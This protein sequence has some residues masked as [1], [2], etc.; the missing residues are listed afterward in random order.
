MT[1]TNHTA[2]KAA[3][4]SLM[5]KPTSTRTPRLIHAVLLLIT[6]GLS[7]LVSAILGPNIP[8]LQEHFASQIAN[9]DQW[10]PLAVSIPIGVFGVC[11]IF[12]GSLSDRIGR[13]N[14]LLWS[15]LLYAIF[16][17][18]PFYIDNFWV[19]FASRVALGV[20]EAAVMTA[21]ATMI[22]DYYTGLKRER[23]ISLQTTMASATATVF[24]AV[25]TAIGAIGWNAPFAV[26]GLALLL[27][28][29][30]AIYLWEPKPK[31][32]NPAARDALQDDGTV[33]RP[34]LLALICLTGFFTGIA[35]MLVPINLAV[36]YVA[37][38]WPQ[39]I[40]V[41][42]TLNSAGVMLATFVFGW[43]L[44]GRTSIG[45]QLFVSL[46]VAG[47]G[48]LM[49]GKASSPDMLTAGAVVNGFGCGLMLPATV[50]WTMR[51]LPFSK[52]GFGIGAF[53]SAQMLGM[54]ISSLVVVTLGN[55]IGSRAAGVAQFGIWMLSAAVIA[56]A[57]G[58][59]VGSQKGVRVG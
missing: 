25:G 46:G 50:T 8:R 19:I 11:A 59:A 45:L 10:V 42:Y 24:V 56:I 51:S 30:M 52:R 32:A 58:L 22:G 2:P 36:L 14:L 1:N 31:V 5:T 9:A 39:Q 41:G 3:T 27:F 57:A 28:P 29:P 48:C 47:I 15:T 33:F 44:A 12:I 38:N 43:V 53:Q 21:S 13:K 34:K 6:S 17:T 7:V 16:G 20:F 18:M 54:A 40:G 23:M 37:A 26:Y 4:K 35:F 49:M 55:S